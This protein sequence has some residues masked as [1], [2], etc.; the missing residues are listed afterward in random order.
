MNLKKKG[1]KRGKIVK[2]LLFVNCIYFPF[3]EHTKEKGKKI[4]K[5]RKYSEKMKEKQVKEVKNKTKSG[6]LFFPPEENPSW[7]YLSL[8][9]TIYIYI[10]IYVIQNSTEFRTRSLRQ[11]LSLT[12][13]MSFTRLS[14]LNPINQS[15][16][17]QVPTQQEVD[18][19]HNFYR[20]HSGIQA[21]FY[22]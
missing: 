6:L 9:L 14:V 10:S 22:I 1:R 4:E 17:V 11:C 3:L 8:S 5:E 15:I 2:M 16:N 19:L 20:V 7:L 13:C 18:Q 12:V 21:G